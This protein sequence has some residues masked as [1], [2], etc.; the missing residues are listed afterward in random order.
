[1]GSAKYRSENPSSSPKKNFLTS[2][3]CVP[4]L[5]FVIF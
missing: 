2:R 1:V 3:V 4:I 5:G